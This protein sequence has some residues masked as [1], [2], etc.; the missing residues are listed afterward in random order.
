[1]LRIGDLVS[2]REPRSQHGIGIRRLTKTSLLWAANTHVQTNTVSGYVVHRIFGADVFAT[3][4]DDNDEFSLIVVPLLVP[5]QAD[6][7]TWSRDRRRRL[8]EKAQ[9]FDRSIESG[10]LR[11]VNIVMDCRILCID[12]DVETIIR[13]RGH[14]FT[15]VGDRTAQLD[16]F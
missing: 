12:L 10:K 6:A 3:L 2:G 5:I 16:S 15:R 8:Q 13:R 7:W 9:G 4:A 1:M 11:V 14:D